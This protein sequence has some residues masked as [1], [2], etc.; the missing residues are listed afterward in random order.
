MLYQFVGDKV[1][2]VFGLHR[3]HAVESGSWAASV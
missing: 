1:V 3:P 2:G